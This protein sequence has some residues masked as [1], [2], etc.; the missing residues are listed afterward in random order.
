[1]K[2][3][4]LLILA[5]VLLGPASSAL[6]TG[7]TPTN[8]AYSSVCSVTNN[9]TTGSTKNLTSQSTLPFTGLDVVLLAAGGGSLL[10]AG[11]V[12]RR[13]SRNLD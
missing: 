12:V 13:L 9:E 2:R 4:A 8:C 7:V 6:A 1:M 5:L 11:F 10:G 3:I